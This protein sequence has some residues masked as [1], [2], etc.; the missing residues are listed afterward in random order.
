MSR[1]VELRQELTIEKR[2]KLELGKNIY[3]NMLKV[4]IDIQDQDI[5]YRKKVGDTCADCPGLVHA[6]Y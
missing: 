3:S 6:N 5:K 1:N 4:P 2:K